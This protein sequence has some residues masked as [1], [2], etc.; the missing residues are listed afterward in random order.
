MYSQPI[1]KSNYY[2]PPVEHLIE[3]I[4]VAQVHFTIAE[5][6]WR[7]LESKCYYPQSDEYIVKMGF[8]L[9]MMA[10]EQTLSRLLDMTDI[11]INHPDLNENWNTVTDFVGEVS[12]NIN[13]YV[14]NEVIPYAAQAA[15]AAGKMA[16]ILQ[17]CQS[18]LQDEA[19]YDRR[20]TQKC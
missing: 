16:H 20:H 1:V 18:Y 14:A 10:G 13:L 12:K 7:K 8:A 11:E 9:S 4:K 17:A 19:E 2:A 6:V 5:D 15:R 3:N